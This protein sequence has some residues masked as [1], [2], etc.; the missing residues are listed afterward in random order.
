MESMNRK[1]I[2]VKNTGKNF[3]LQSIVAES[4]KEKAPR[5]VAGLLDFTIAAE[6]QRLT[7]YYSHSIVAGGLPDTS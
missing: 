1:W 6:C 5:K 2:T 3:R 7:L 4:R